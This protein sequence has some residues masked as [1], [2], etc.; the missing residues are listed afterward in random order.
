M[1]TK[2]KENL[3]EI[4]KEDFLFMNSLDKLYKSALQIATIKS[5]IQSLPSQCPYN[6]QQT[7]DENYQP[8]ILHNEQ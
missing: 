5:N 4:Y 2:T 7:I 6:F 8:E 1:L 3:K